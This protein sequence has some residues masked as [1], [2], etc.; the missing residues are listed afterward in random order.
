VLFI[1]GDLSGTTYQELFIKH[2]LL[3]ASVL[4]RTE[5][6]RTSSQTFSHFLR[7]LKGRSQMGQILLGRSDFLRVLGIAGLWQS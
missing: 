4:Q 7:Q 1:P 5:Q 3:R 2:Y 6:K